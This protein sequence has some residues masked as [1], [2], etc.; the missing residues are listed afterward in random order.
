MGAMTRFETLKGKGSAFL[1]LLWFL[2]FLNFSF[3]TIFSPLLP[4]IED[5]FQ[6][7][8]AAAAALFGLTS[9]GYGVSVF[10]AGIGTG[11]VGC[12]RVI[13]VSLLLSSCVCLLIPAVQDFHGFM[14]C[15]F[16][17]GLSTGMY[18]PAAIPII[19]QRFRPDIWGR[20]LAIHDS[21][22][23]LSIFAVPFLAL[24]L[25]DFLSWKHVFA[26]L[27]AIGLAATAAHCLVN[28]EAVITRR[29]DD[30]VLEGLLRD[31]A[32][33]IMGAMWVF[34][35]GA[36]MGLY[37]IIPLYLT[38]ELGFDVSDANWMFGWSRIGGV[39]VSIG[40]GF[41]VDR[42]S[43]KKTMG[44]LLLSTGVLTA[45]LAVK[46]VALIRAA[47]FLQASVAPGFFP[48]GL[49]AISRLFSDKQR[50]MATGFILTLGVIFG[51]GGVPYLLG[52][53]G[54]LV[55]F[56]VGIAVLGFC[57]M[58]SSGLAWR[59]R[60]DET[61]QGHRKRKKGKMMRL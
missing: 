54:D 18:L 55:S 22:A 28:K 57:V 45:V 46:D 56:R 29:K 43:L 4:L 2:W 3:R 32:I 9:L 41:I 12:K 16:V 61:A 15:A 26:L 5:D 19:A 34:A 24:F 48:A 11:L 37:S 44:F 10:F 25:L 39:I 17:I 51:L 23:S 53:A 49:V 47:L 42:F 14:I 35:C 59:L 20:S 36:S 8:H 58:A 6:I 30:R 40:T 52:L 31:P 27:G 7:S 1:L 60:R 50:S 33:W 13:T 21:A 38:K